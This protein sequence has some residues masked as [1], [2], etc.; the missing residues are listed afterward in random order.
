MSTCQHRRAAGVIAGAVLAVASMSASAQLAPTPLFTWGEEAPGGP[1][2]F[3]FPT[4]IAVDDAT[5]DIWVVDRNYELATRYDENGNYILEFPCMGCLGIE[6][7]PATRAVY[8]GKVNNETVEQ[9]TVDGEFVRSWGGLGTGP[10]QFNDPRNLAIDPETNDIYVFDAKNARIQVFD[11]DINYLREWGEQGD[12]PGLFRGGNA[13]FSIAFDPLSRSIVAIDPRNNNVQ[14]FD[15]NGTLLDFWDLTRSW[16]RNETRWLRDVEIDVNGEVMIADSDNERIQSFSPEG[17]TTAL[18]RGLHGNGNEP[19]HP[20]SIAVNRVTGKRYAMAAYAHRVDVFDADNRYEFSFG[21]QPDEQFF[22]R[23]PGA[24]AVLPGSGDVVVVD[25]KN[26]RMKRFTG[27]GEFVA[28]WGV[29]SRIA[30][31][32]DRTNAPVMGFD[33]SAMEVDSNGVIYHA[34]SLTYYADPGIKFMQVVDSETG[35]L[36]DAWPAAV[37]SSSDS[38]GVAIDEVGGRIFV[39]EPREAKVAVYDRE[40]NLIDAIPA[41]NATGLAYGEQGLFVASSA[42][43]CIRRYSGALELEVEWGQG[44]SGPGEFAFEELSE[45]ALDPDGNLYVT[46]TANDRIQGFD[47]DGNFLWELGVR[48]GNFGQFRTPRGIAI[49]PA[50]DRLYVVDGGNSRIY[51]MALNRRDGANN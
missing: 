50:A 25:E 42:C 32:V 15:L 49:D 39:S 21:G 33:V 31:T 46:D 4:G 24:I 22:L 6:I 40:G 13:P 18:F 48:G 35:R 12:G 19:F 47:A 10:G 51:A 38:T 20:R 45:I 5:G 34:S 2:I 36:L 37:N 3:G 9:W 23:S 17:V 8:V 26:F 41:D 28:E 1:A 11:E 30:A 7:N 16:P 43:Q 14:R 27:D 29:S 44:G